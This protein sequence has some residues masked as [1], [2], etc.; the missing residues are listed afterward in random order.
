M[1]KIL[2]TLFFIQSFWWLL[3]SCHKE[4]TEPVII[5]VQQAPVKEIVNNNLQWTINKENG[6]V[7]AKLTYLD[8]RPIANSADSI[9]AVYILGDSDVAIRRGDPRNYID[10][11]YQVEKNFIVLHKRI[12]KT[13]FFG[14]WTFGFSVASLPKKAKVVFR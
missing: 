6:I 13:E 3:S 2:T 1:K 11:Y 12:Q 9:L 5:R 7:S 10:I 4:V 14:F 8:G